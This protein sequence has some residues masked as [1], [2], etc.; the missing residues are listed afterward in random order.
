MSKL[1]KIFIVF[2]ALIVCSLF[3]FYRMLYHSNL[4]TVQNINGWKDFKQKTVSRNAFLATADFSMN[5]R[6]I[7]IDYYLKNEVDLNNMDSVFMST[8]N[9]L[10]N[11]PVYSE[12]LKENKKHY[13]NSFGSIDIRFYYPKNEIFYEFTS[14]ASN[15]PVNGKLLASRFKVWSISIKNKYVKDY[16][17]NQ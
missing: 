9:F 7:S 17:E 14:S 4:Y 6:I 12:L 1:I 3:L 8:K 15:I 5:A 11:E 16:I 13:S 10:L 2:F